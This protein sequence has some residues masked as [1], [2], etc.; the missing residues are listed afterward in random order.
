M[1][2]NSNV[3][4]KNSSASGSRKRTGASPASKTSS[5]SRNAGRSSGKKS[6]NRSSRKAEVSR[7]IPMKNEIQLVASFGIMILMMLSN[8]GW[9]G[10]CDGFYLYDVFDTE[11]GPVFDDVDVKSHEVDYGNYSSSLSYVIGIRK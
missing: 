6:G 5:R 1:A 3:K 8:F 4:K 2:D 11:E 9:C 7:G 10:G